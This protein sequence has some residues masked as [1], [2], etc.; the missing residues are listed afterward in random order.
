VRLAGAANLAFES[1]SAGLTGYYRLGVRARP[2]DLDGKKH[3]ISTKLLRRGLTLANT[4]RVFAATKSPAADALASG[5]AQAALRAALESP[6]PE[7]A[8]DV[9]A[10][11][12]VTHADAGVRDV[13]VVVVGDVARAAAGTAT[14]VAALYDLNGK[15]VSAMENVIQVAVGGGG[16]VTIELTVPAALY[17]LRMA[18]RDAAGHIGSLER[19]VD[20]RWK[21]VGAIETPGLVLFRSALGASTP[22]G[23]V[24]DSI[25]RSEQLIAQ[26][27]LSPSSDRTTPIVFEVTRPGDPVAA[28]RRHA[29]IAETT[30][31]VLVARDALPAVTLPPGRYTMTARIG[32]GSATL[33]RAF[34][35][36]AVGA[37]GAGR[38]AR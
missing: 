11:A 5:D 26:L 21:K 3:K 9:R 29:R 33:S 22:S 30:A 10:G 8:L 7:L 25:A 1:L 4:R 36:V 15:P 38:A 16:P 19:P 27:T 6:S 37:E 14:A 18:V 2:E 12:Y 17:V 13:R 31:G 20:A 24:L 28:A 32:D 34:S 35:I 23:L